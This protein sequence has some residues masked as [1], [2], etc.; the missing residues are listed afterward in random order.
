MAELPAAALDARDLMGGWYASGLT[1]TTAEQDP[2]ILELFL[3]VNID[4][5]I[6]VTNVRSSPMR[7]RIRTSRMIRINLSTR[8]TRIALKF[9]TVAS[10]PPLAA[11]L[12]KVSDSSK[13][14]KMT[15]T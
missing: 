11:Q 13:S 6:D 7:R 15:T 10:S 9:G 4:G 12:P 3:T 14:C 2:T 5:T 1:A 8:R